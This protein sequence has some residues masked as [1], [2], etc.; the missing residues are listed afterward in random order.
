MRILIL[1][2]SYGSL[3]STKLLMAG[4]DVTLVCREVTAALINSEGTQVRLKLRDEDEHRIIH[5]KD[6]PGTVNAATPHDVKPSEYDLVC[7]A[8]QESRYRKSRVYRL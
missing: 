1:G 7:L 3:L 5:S 6:H 2:A 4:H 8:M